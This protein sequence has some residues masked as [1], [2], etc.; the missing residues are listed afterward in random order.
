L[1]VDQG[2]IIFRLAAGAV[3]VVNPHE[4]RGFQVAGYVLSSAS[5]D[6]RRRGSIVIQTVSIL[7]DEISSPNEVFFAPNPAC[8]SWVRILTY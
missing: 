7:K 4:D 1:A 6:E 3:L 8:P 2:V 5:R